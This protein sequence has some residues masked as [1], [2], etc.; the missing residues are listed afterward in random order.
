VQAVEQAGYHA[1]VV[2]PPKSDG[3]PPSHGPHLSSGRRSD[4]VVLGGGSAGFAASIRAAELGA[5]VTLIEGGTL[6]GTCVNVGC[7]PSKTLIRAAEVQ[8][9]AVRHGFYG[10]RTSADSPDFQKVVV[11][12]DALVTSMRQ[13]KYWDVIRAYPSV[14]LRQSRGTIH[15]DLSDTLTARR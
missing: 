6:G 13:E 8:H 15:H 11:Q 12:K 10:V 1:S 14:T 5:R 4:V 9:R 7:V 2:A 3:A